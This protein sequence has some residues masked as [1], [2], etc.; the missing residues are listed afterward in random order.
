ML[1][2]RTSAHPISDQAELLICVAASQAIT[3]AG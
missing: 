1:D 3:L 2:P